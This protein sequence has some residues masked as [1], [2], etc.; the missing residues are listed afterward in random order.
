[1]IALTL[2]LSFLL[3]IIFSNIVSSTGIFV[4]L[5]FIVSLVIV[6]PYFKSKLYF[7]ITCLICG[8]VYDLGFFNTTFINTICFTLS[9]L[10]IMNLHSYINYNLVSTLIVNTI[11]LIINRI[12]S[13]LFLC[14]IAYNK[15]HILTLFRGIYSSLLI[16]I[17]YGVILFITLEFIS[18]KFNVKKNE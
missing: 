16:N 4:P 14:L 10:F 9:G 11:I 13:Y 6:Y 2:V 12:L 3:E 1:M 15:F 8:I 17:I 18:R 7:I 5:F